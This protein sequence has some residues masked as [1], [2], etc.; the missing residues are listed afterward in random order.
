MIGAAIYHVLP[1][2]HT[3]AVTVIVPPGGLN[4]HMLAQHIESKFF[5]LGNVIDQ[6]I[7]G[8]GGIES[9]RPVALIQDSIQKEGLVIQAE[10]G[11]PF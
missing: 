5:H 10:T 7:V 3:E 1:Y 2:D 4:L 11:D 9:V 8:R 6:S